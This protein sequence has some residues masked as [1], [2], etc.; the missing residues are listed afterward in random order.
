M[1]KSIGIILIMV[2]CCQVSHAKTKG[3]DFVV[4]KYGLHF[5]MDGKIIKP[6]EYYLVRASENINKGFNESALKNFRKAASYGNTLGA[7]YSGL[8]YLQ[9]NDAIRGYA[10]LNIANAKGF[11]FKDKIT[12]LLWKLEQQ[13][14]DMEL[15]NA[16][17]FLQKLDKVYG[18]EPTLKR[19]L[20]WTRGFKLTGSNVS[21]NVTRGTKIRTDMSAGSGGLVN[22]HETTKTNTLI[23]NM[24]K[25]EELSSFVYHYKNDFR[26]TEGEVNVRDIEL[27]KEGN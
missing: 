12:D 5:D 21:G 1:N 18:V 6:D 13:M 22:F 8:L 27:S 2:L 7:Y 23:D 26:L 24:N 16:K 14:S 9:D 20:K 19:R 17:G 25:K 15:G 11:E 3:N 10:W 4:G